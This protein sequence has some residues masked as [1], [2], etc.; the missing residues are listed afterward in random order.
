MARQASKFDDRQERAAKPTEVGQK[1]AGPAVTES[2]NDN[3]RRLLREAAWAQMFGRAEAKN[4]FG[5]R[6]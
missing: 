5:S 6:G 1:T 3:P 4:P 2:T